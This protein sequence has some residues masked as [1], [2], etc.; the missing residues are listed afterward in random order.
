MP[1][2]GFYEWQARGKGPKQPYWIRPQDGSL[3]AFAGL[4]E[5]WSGPNGEELDTAAIITTE[6]NAPLKSIHGR[7]PVVLAPDLFDPWLDPKTPADALLAFLRP[8][9][10]NLLSAVAISARVN[11]VR[12]DGPDLW[13]P[14]DG[15]TQDAQ[16]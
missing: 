12:N 4:W 6:A 8:A 2:T 14:A 11:A 16:A 1:A 7:M 3:I 5:C 13:L 10:D 15:M 9:G